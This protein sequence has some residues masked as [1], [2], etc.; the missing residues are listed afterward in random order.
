MADSNELLKAQIKGYTK[1]DG[2]YVSTHTRHGD[3]PPARPASLTH[4]PRRGEKGE[5]VVIKNPSHASA[6]STWHSA[7]SV[8]TFLPDGDTPP[9]LNGIPMTRWRDA[10]LTNLGW[11]FVDG[12]NEDLD[13]PPLH[14]P[15]GKK[16]AA[17]VVIEEPDGRIWLIAPT[18]Q[19]GSYE[20]SFPKG[21]AEPDLSLQANALKECYEE[22]GLQVEI[23]G[24]IGDFPR[25]TSVARMYRARRVGGSPSSMGWE[26]QAVHLVPKSKLNEYL[27]MAPDHAVTESITKDHA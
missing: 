25:T 19:F 12:I 7:T 20:A 21:T 9:S 13:E 5:R 6:P 22:S 16:P 1:K 2:T 18:N 17:G 14:V 23:T 15:P 24:F 4:H 11:E 3:R 10:P 27:N 26:S 8:A